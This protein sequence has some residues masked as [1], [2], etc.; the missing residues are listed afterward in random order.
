MVNII[1]RFSGVF[2]ELYHELINALG[3]A[4]VGDFWK[5]SAEFSTN[6]QLTP[7]APIAAIPC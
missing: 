6:V 2:H 3:S 1:L 5:P 7:S 4:A